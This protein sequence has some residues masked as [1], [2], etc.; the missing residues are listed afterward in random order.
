MKRWQFWVGLLISAVCLYVFMIRKQNWAKLWNSLRSAQ[1][2][3]LIPA[4]AIYFIGV[5]SPRLAAA[6]P[7]A[8]DQDRFRSRTLFP[9]VCIAYM[10]NNIFPAR[11]GEAAHSRHT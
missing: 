9:I 3:W 11:A 5:W 10:G 4:I 2:L 7:D 1:Y 8:A 6:L